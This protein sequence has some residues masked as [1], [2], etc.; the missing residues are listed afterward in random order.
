MMT[1]ERTSRLRVTFDKACEE[2]GLG[3]DND[4]KGRREHLAML[5]VVSLKGGELDP[6]L[7]RAQAIHQML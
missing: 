6:N 4:D 5:M 3:K 7:H 2:L 1:A